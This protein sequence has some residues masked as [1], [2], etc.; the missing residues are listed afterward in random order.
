MK[1]LIVG[2]AIAAMLAGVV[3]FPAVVL[4]DSLLLAPPDGEK[5][6]L[7]TWAPVVYEYPV[8]SGTWY[9]D[10]VAA[11][12]DGIYYTLSVNAVDPHVTVEYCDSSYST[13]GTETFAIDANVMDAA[14][15]RHFHHR[16][17][18]P[19][20]ADPEKTV[21]ATEVSTSDPAFPKYHY[22]TTNRS[23]AYQ[24]IS[25]SIVGAIDN[26]TLGGGRV[27]WTLRVTNNSGQLAGPIRVAGNEN[28][29]PVS[30]LLNCYD[31]TPDDPAKALLLEQGASTT[32]TVRGLAP[33]PLAP[34]LSLYSRDSGNLWVE[35]ELPSLIGTVTCAGAPLEGVT[36]TPAGNYRPTTTIANG[37]YAKAGLVGLPGGNSVTFSKPGYYQQTLTIVLSGSGVVRQNVSLVPLHGT[38][39]GTVSAAVTGEGLAG[40]TVALSGAAGTSVSGSHGVYRTAD[41]APGDYS[42][43]ISKPGY[44][45]KTV[46]VTIGNDATTT[47][48]AA[49]NITPS[50]SRSP[51]ASSV[52]YRRRRGKVKY[53]LSATV[54][55]FGAVPVP[56][57]RVRLE[58]SA[59]G[60]TKWKTVTTLTSD[61]AG[62]AAKS[63]TSR[64]RSTTYYRWVVISQTGVNG[65]PKT[66][67]QKVKVK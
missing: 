65:T 61:A 9:F 53:T 32:F 5:V 64:K 7:A 58:K 37:Q 1:R 31:V 26:T 67:K 8:G 34:D 18:V 56:G 43:T 35:A 20:G 41:I 59:N 44:D 11:N 10:G 12:Y 47:L 33:T 22:A 23:T 4:G 14:A 45:S 16:L 15:F 25:S 36:V 27:L 39:T 3:L 17:T 62:G 29:G 66:T 63:Y 40:A 42:A 21:F 49:L 60:R 38:L 6:A 48:N 28:Y 57:V 13:V 30:S 55:G 19:A 54:K 2:L 24:G 52:I 46:P 50:V 51:K